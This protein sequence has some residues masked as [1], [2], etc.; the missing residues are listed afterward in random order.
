MP[1]ADH[2]ETGAGWGPRPLRS[3]LVALGFTT[4]FLLWVL[5]PGV[6]PA[7]LAAYHWSSNVRALY[8]PIALDFGIVWVFV[9]LLLLVAERVGGKTRPAIWSAL[10]LAIPWIGYQTACMLLS[11]FP[12]RRY[13]EPLFFAALL[14]PALLAG[15]WQP[16]WNPRL[17]RILRPVGT[18]LLFVG[19]FGVVL[20]GRLGLHGWRAAHWA[21]ARPA[22]RTPATAAGQPHRI[23]WILFDELAYRPVFEN[24]YPGLK[25]PAFDSLASQSTNFTNVV[26]PDIY[27]QVVLPSLMSGQAFD[28]IR[29]SASGRPWLRSIPSGEWRSFD[30]HDTAFEDAVDAG[31]GTAVAGWFNPYCRLLPEVLDQCFW[32]NRWPIS[33]GMY[34]GDTVGANVLAPLQPLRFMITTALPRFLQQSRSFQTDS[35]AQKN[36][37]VHAMDY[38][39][40]YA[41]AETILKDRNAGFVLLHLPIPHPFGIYDRKTGMI[42]TSASTYVDNLALADRCLAGI[43]STLERTGQWDSSTIVVMGDHSWRV[44]QLWKPASPW[45]K[46]DESASQ[47]AKYDPR[48]AYLVK[49]PGQTS[50]TTVDGAF[51]S[52]N[53]RKLLDGIMTKKITSPGALTTWAQ[54]LK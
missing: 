31:Y 36:R 7:Q 6:D 19:L 5:E 22:L 51:H 21:N 15:F 29:I 12:T 38:A 23:I 4:I 42:T 27:T 45:T 17:D 1:V 46:E 41:A 50:G 53:T 54:S 20:L 9:A 8:I 14:T 43:R 32:I 47:G 10:L 11:Y 34:I 28:R 3:L 26:P 24:R 35:I 49:L 33:N 25:M 18:V 44:T 48:P 52:V 39:D 40:I 16:A 30:Q 13:S 2:A 37:R